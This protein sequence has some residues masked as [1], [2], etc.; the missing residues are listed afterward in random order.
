[1]V[2]GL[3][4]GNLGGVLT[5]RLA[6]E[7]G[8]LA[9]AAAAEMGDQQGEREHG[10]PRRRRARRRGARSFI[11]GVGTAVGA[12]IGAAPTGGLYLWSVW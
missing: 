4:L 12:G 9:R 8:H 6:P 3:L 11:S 10:R 5:V 1:L 7:R 2:S